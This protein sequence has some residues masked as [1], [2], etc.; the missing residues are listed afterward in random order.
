MAMVVTVCQC[1]LSLLA[2]ISDFSQQ[3]ENPVK[4]LCKLNCSFWGGGGE[5]CRLWMAQSASLATRDDGVRLGAQPRS[6][7][8]ASCDVQIVSTSFPTGWR[9][10]SLFLSF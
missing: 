1:P 8:S 5:G 6:A 4:N 10:K 2:K 7:A 3:R 9:N